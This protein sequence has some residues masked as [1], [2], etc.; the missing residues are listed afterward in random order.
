M[1][2]SHSV[3][4]NM[5]MRRLKHNFFKKPRIVKMFH[6]KN[7]CVFKLKYVVNIA[8]MSLFDLLLQL[9]KKLFSYQFIP[10]AS[11]DT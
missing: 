9:T 10:N 5:N 6:Y 3:I 11:K 2:S 7:V 4:F 1:I 8:K